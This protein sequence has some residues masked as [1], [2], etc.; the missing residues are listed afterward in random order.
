MHRLHRALLLWVNGDMESARKVVEELLR[1]DSNDKMVF[2]VLTKTRA[3][4]GTRL[5]PASVTRN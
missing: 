3:Y 5:A 1:E 2:R 4:T